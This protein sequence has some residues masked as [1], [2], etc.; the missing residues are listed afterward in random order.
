MLP[1][2][3][4][5]LAA[6][7]S[8]ISTALPAPTSTPTAVT[9]ATPIP[10]IANAVT[11]IAT[12]STLADVPTALDKVVIDPLG[13]VHMAPGVGQGRSST[14]LVV[15]RTGQP[16]RRYDLHGNFEP[17]AFAVTQSLL[18]VLEYRPPTKPTHY[19]VQSLDLV[20]GEL[21]P[22][23]SRDKQVD[24]EEM[25]GDRKGQIRS[26][27]GTMLYTLYEPHAAPGENGHHF[28]HA[29]SLADSW[30]HCIDLPQGHEWIDL[31]LAKGMLTV[32][33]ADGAVAVVDPDTMV[34][35]L[36]T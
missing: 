29:L 25:A 18:F 11:A 13:T 28:V 33:A 16:L 36:Q 2:I 12:V 31:H 9:I 32:S 27:D 21:R 24:G 22:L 15:E 4:I 6:C 7:S 8:E 20:T 5:G 23:L 17:E 35:T 34:A 30:T 14:A 10:D 26:D 1:A 3:L 19:R